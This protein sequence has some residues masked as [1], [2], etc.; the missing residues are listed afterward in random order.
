MALAP[1]SVVVCSTVVLT[2]ALNYLHHHTRVPQKQGMGRSAL[3]KS[4][5][6]FALLVSLPFLALLLV[7][8]PVGKAVD[9][10]IA[11]VAN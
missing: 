3:K 5:W 4:A 6:L 1:P 8:L 11:V 10:L 2:T 9:E 7:V